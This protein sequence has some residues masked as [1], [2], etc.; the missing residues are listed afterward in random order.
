MQQQL[1]G[2]RALVCGA[3]A[4]IG[5]AA[6]EALAA[7]GASVTLAARDLGKLE[8]TR[9]ALPTTSGQTHAIMQADFTRPAEVR[10]GA[11]RILAD[12]GPHHILINNTGG[13][14][15]GPLLNA[16]PE[17]FAFAIDT[18]LLSAHHLV[19]ALAPGMKAARFGRIV[20]VISTS[21][22]QPI[23]GL[24]VSNTARG[25]VANWAK[26]LAGELGPAGITVNN[27]LPGFTR[28]D[29]LAALVK[30]NAAKR[31]LTEAAIEAEMLASIPAG[32][33]A[34]PA[35]TAAAIAF[36][37]SPL[38]GYINGINLPV[39]GGRLACL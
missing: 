12:H 17:Q 2:K 39:D 13:P 18:Q 19:Q 27:V 11:E 26:T 10:R 33:F 30:A 5:R 4:G 32:R 37:A 29:R 8:S 1:S 7:M 38:A 16:T 3:T 6:A 15:G 28:T 35:E 24:G 14:P 20:N 21:V 36:L 31:G 34:D 22:K 9:A 25:A 23:P